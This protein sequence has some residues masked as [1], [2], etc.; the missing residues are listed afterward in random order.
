[1]TQ[2]YA[3]VLFDGVC[4]LCNSWVQR[5]IKYDKRRYFRFASIQSE[6]GKRIL[7]KY[8]LPIGDTPES[9]VLIENNKAYCYS[10]AALRIARKLNSAWKFFYVAIILPRFFR[11]YI[12]KYIARNRYKW[13]G[14]KAECMVPT[15]ELQSLFLE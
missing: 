11:D 7:E 4:N 10:S 2:Q 8:N 5:I 1:M 3:I 6:A 14:K 13:F 12:Y 15:P 9:L